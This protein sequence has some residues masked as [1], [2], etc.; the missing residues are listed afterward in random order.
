MKAIIY[1]RVS[2]SAQ[3]YVRQLDELLLRKDKWCK[4]GGGT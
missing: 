3:D 4:E 1:A 2:T